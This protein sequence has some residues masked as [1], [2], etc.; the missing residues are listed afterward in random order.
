MVKIILADDHS[1]MRGGL[2]KLIEQL[3]NVIVVKECANGI[4]V[5]DFME[6]N[7]KVDLVISDL[8]MPEMNG[9][10]MTMA[11]QHAHPRIKIIILSMYDDLNQVT[12]AIQAGVSA[13]L[14][15]SS[16][17][18]ELEFAIRMV[19]KNHRYIGIALMDKI[20]KTHLHAT[21][22]QHPADTNHYTEREL[23]VLAM[24]AEGMTNI[25][26]SNSLFLSKRTVEGH[27]QNLLL[28]TG[29]KNTA[30]LIRYAVI[31]KLID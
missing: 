7:E 24:I 12:Q 28:K 1:I 19:H 15:K 27:R 9:L 14:P 22:G 29:S 11:L 3:E 31:N 5:M 26:I 23:E 6:T 10:E 16:E 30:T 17:M 18:D 20:I 2:R 21:A 4:E 13:Y 25:E 8:N